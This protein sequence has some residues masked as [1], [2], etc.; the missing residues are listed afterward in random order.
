MKR[1]RFVVLGLAA[2]IQIVG[3]KNNDVCYDEKNNAVISTSRLPIRKMYIDKDH[4][5]SLVCVRVKSLDVKVSVFD[6]TNGD[7]EIAYNGKVFTEEGHYFPLSSYEIGHYTIGDADIGVI[8]FD[9]DSVGMPV[10][11]SSVCQ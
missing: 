4:T 9:T 1:M 5:S 6:I 2:W 7:F 8:R 3:C 11:T 10:N